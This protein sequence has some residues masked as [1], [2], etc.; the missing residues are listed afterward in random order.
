MKIYSQNIWGNF[1]NS[2]CIGNRNELIKQLIDDVNPNFLCFQECNPS[3]SRS[4]T[5]AINL[6]IKDNYYEASSKNSNVNFT[7]V[8]YK[9]KGIE[10]IEDGFKVFEGLND[11]N[12]KSYTWAVY[13]DL[14][15]NKYI[16]IISVH[17][18]WKYT[19]EVDDLQRRDNAKDVVSKAKNISSK[20]NCPVII[21]GDFNSGVNTKQGNDAYNEMIKLGMKDIRQICDESTDDFTCSYSYPKHTED[22]IY[23]DGQKPTITID[24]VFVYKSEL[25]KAKKFSV[26]NSQ[27]ARNSS[28][29]SP[30]VFE[31]ELI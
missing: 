2:E 10:L 25:I 13:K 1:S 22:G 7:P 6:L 19:G 16:C 27:I 14:K 20:Y 5:K 11:W 31:L 8:F 4:G 21:A 3:T 28:D 23:Y 30:L 26:I 12:S 15:T 18:W 29:H 24:Y 17:F 9:N